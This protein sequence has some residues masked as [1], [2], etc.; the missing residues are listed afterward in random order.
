MSVA[1]LIFRI[2]ARRDVEG[3]GHPI[4]RYFALQAALFFRD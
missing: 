4:D 3:T 1:S 2:L